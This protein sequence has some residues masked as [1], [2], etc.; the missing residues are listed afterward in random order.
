MSI[1]VTLTVQGSELAPTLDQVLKSMTNEDKRKLAADIAYRHFALEMADT[2]RMDRYNSDERRKADDYLKELVKEVKGTVSKTIFDDY[3]LKSKIEAV[4]ETIRP[5]L[6]Q[7]VERAVV[8]ILAGN[9]A[10]LFERLATTEQQQFKVAD[11]LQRLA[12]K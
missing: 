8:S 4:L 1:Q 11:E 7:F 5:H 10:S 12:S 3:K 2:Y 6:H 9:V